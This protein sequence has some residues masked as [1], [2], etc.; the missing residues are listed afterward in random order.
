[1][2]S[3]VGRML[4]VIAALVVTS[5]VTQCTLPTDEIQQTVR[6]NYAPLNNG[7]HV[8]LQPDIPVNLNLSSNIHLLSWDTVKDDSP[9]R[10]DQ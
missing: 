8:R 10:P 3:I 5:D 2:Y 4:F 1:M 9:G 7:Q 6:D